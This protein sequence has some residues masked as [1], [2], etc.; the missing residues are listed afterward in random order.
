MK[1]QRL[2]GGAEPL[3]LINQLETDFY[4]SGGFPIE[5]KKPQIPGKLTSKDNV[6]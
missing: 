1:Y 6:R 2:V 3:R 4:P 5:H